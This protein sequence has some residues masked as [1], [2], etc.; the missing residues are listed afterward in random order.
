M[1]Y[2]KLSIEFKGTVSRVFEY[3][4]KSSSFFELQKISPVRAL[5]AVS[6]G[7]Y[8]KFVLSTFSFDF[9]SLL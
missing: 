1:Q 4:L 2:G 7:K 9:R 5:H 3:S 6:K 8:R